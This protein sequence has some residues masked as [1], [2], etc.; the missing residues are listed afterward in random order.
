MDE[1]LQM[2]EKTTK[3][4]QKKFDENEYLISQR[5]VACEKIL[6]SE[7]SSEL[8]KVKALLDRT[9]DYDRLERLSSQLS[10]LYILQI[11]VFKVKI[12]Q[13]SIDN[14]ND[15]LTTSGILEKTKDIENTKKKIN[16]L[17]ILLEAHYESMKK[18]GNEQ[19]KELSYVS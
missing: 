16:E 18:I 1:I 15:Q 19:E 4:T 13:I 2:L 7:K 10:L 9:Q 17:M 6:K 11:F 3:K 14:I 12:L 8:H 5:M